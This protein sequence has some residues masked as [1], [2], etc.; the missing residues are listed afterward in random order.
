MAD[1]NLGTAKG[2]VEIGYDGKGIT[3][4]RDDLGRFVGGKGSGGGGAGSISSAQASFTK[5]ATIS[6]AATATVAAGIGFA[7]NAAIDFEKGISAIG[8]VSGATAN[9]LELLRAK[10]LK[11]GADTVF[12]AS[13]AA[14]AMEELAKAGI[15]VTDILGGAADATVALAAAGEI[16]LPQAATIAANAMNQF[17]LAAKDLPK[18]ADLIAGAANA[19]AIDVSDFGLA[20]QQAGAVANLTGLKFQDLAVAIALMGN[21]GI[22][23]SDAGTS[24]KTMLQNLIP[25]TKQQIALSKQLGLI[26]KDG[27]NAFFDAQGHVKS[28]ADVA[29]ILSKALSGLTDEQKSLALQTLFGSDAIRAAAV[30]SNAGAAGFNN[31]A[32]AMAKTSAADVAKA[33]MDNVAGSIEQLKGSIDTAAITLGTVLLPVIR[34]VT[35]VITL[36]VNKFSALD[37]KWQKMIAFALVAGAALIGLVAIVAG[38]AAAIAALAST[39]IGAGIVAGIAGVVVAVIALATA[40]K[41][42]YDRSQQFRDLLGKLVAVAKGVFG[43]IMAVVTPLV[44]FFRND[45]IPAVI[46]MSQTFT[47]NLQPAIKAI[48]EFISS[49]ILPALKQLQEAFAKAMPTII[50]VGKVILDIAGFILNI[51]GKALGF[52]IP[53][54]L[55]IIGPIFSALITVISAV[56]GFIP[57]LVAGFIAIWNVLKTIGEIIAIAVIAPFYAIY[58]AGKFVFEHLLAGVQAFVAAFMAVWN[59][60]WPVTK[61]VFDLIVAIVSLAFELITG[62]FQVFWQG[63]LVIW[64][65]LWEFLIKPVIAGLGLIASFIGGKLAE[66]WANFQ[67]FWSLVVALWNAVWNEIVPPTI[68]KFNLIKDIITTVMNFISDHI[69]AVWNAIVGFFTTARDRTVN[70]INNFT[71]IIDRARAIFQ[72]MKDAAVAQA[73]ALVAWVQG[74]PGRLLSALGNI[75]GMLVNAGRALIQGFWDGMKGIWNSLV[76]WLQDKMS[77]LRGLWPFSPAKWG[78]FSGR[79]WVL[80]SGRALMEGFAQGM[81]DRVGLV[82]DAAKNAL[83]NVAGSL[84]TDFAAT[85][86][87]ATTGTGLTTGLAGSGT[88][89]TPATGDTHHTEI[90]INVP[91]DDLRKITDV[92]DLL[93]FIDRLRNDSRRGLVNA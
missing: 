92:K 66:V 58:L 60:L 63:I 15:S 52:I 18:V 14:T 89:A 13:D 41:L 12:S 10:A 28:L 32:A 46:S 5:L 61:A 23:G 64:N 77:T 45:V 7:V 72:G 80:Y 71:V 38:V 82:N 53:L 1:Y 88:V 62:A 48:S 65:A 56:I 29:G 40:V 70:A 59:F 91:L 11:L 6:A 33:R 27:S 9:Q 16:D 67:G 93:D 87:I 31:L 36:L 86:G 24:L 44:A 49:R 73:E 76:G 68:A 8:A 19:S 75:G 83:S 42:A 25:T 34:K 2:K 20:M 39:G 35:D 26:T 50:Q 79:G 69:A 30:L 84:P 21:A 3:Q 85:V 81:D 17:G 47:K 90:N 4:A 74:L 43:V 57:S 55:N 51:L 54:L 22:K 78:P 37:P